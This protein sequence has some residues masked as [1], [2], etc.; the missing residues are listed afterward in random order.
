MEKVMVRK[1]VTRSPHRE[2]GVVNPSWLL[3]HAVEHE[4]HLE[5]RF[6]MVALS[7]PIVIDIVHQPLQIWLGPNDT[8][9]YTPDFKVTFRDGDSVIIEVKPEAFA[10]KHAERLHAAERG[11][12]AMGQRFLLVTD[13]HID[14]NGL[15]ARAMLLMRYGRLQFTDEE[16]L[17]CLRLL[18]AE[19][20]GSTSVHALAEKGVSEAIIWNLVAKHQCRVPAGLCM[21]SCET[22]SII[23]PMGVCY[24]LFCA[25]FGITQG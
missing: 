11:F 23:E 24:D 6:I 16:A 7:C 22:V 8:Q 4:S 25:W 13:R 19:F 9:R 10:A 18:S 14:A 12:N 3:D 20:D 21:D 17:E 1:I 15:S 2:V 5:R